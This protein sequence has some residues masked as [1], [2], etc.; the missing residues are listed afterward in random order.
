M[1]SW[2]TN[3]LVIIGNFCFVATA[4]RNESDGLACGVT[5]CNSSSSQISTRMENNEDI[6]L[7]TSTI[8]G[9][10]VTDEIGFIQAQSPLLQT[11]TSVQCLLLFSVIIDFIVL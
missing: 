9:K 6:Y 10:C 1:M 5:Q 3:Y 8:K 11:G 4:A 2:P 7:I